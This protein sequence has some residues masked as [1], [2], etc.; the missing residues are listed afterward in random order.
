VVKV[1]ARANPFRAQGAAAGADAKTRIATHR[2]GSRQF[3]ACRPFQVLIVKESY[4]RWPN[5]NLAGN[6]I[7]SYSMRIARA[8]LLPK[9][10][11][12]PPLSRPHTQ[13]LNSDSNFARYYI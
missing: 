3:P 12:N 2:K 1:D 4:W 11:R 5:R 13:R 10:S 7:D 8:I 6:T 9:G